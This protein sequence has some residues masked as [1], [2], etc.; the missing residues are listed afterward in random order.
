MSES[1]VRKFQNPG[2]GDTNPE[3]LFKDRALCEAAVATPGVA[4]SS[5]LM[6]HFEHHRGSLQDMAHASILVLDPCS[7]S[8]RMRRIRGTWLVHQYVLQSTQ[9]GDVTEELATKCLLNQ[10]KKAGRARKGENHGEKD[11]N[12]Y[13]WK[14]LIV[15]LYST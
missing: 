2:Q 6:E 5:K 9:S 11:F 14:F 10:C 1:T 8:Y 13:I 7:Y 12:K 3:G 15:I 4:P